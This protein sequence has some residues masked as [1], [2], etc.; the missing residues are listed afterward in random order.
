MFYISTFYKCFKFLDFIKFETL[1]RDF[2]IKNK[3]KGTFIITPE[4]INATI[5]S[6]EE[7]SLEDLKIFIMKK[8]GDIDFKYSLSNKSP[9]KKLKIKI[10]NELVPSGTK[11]RPY[12]F[13]SQYLNADEWNEFLKNDNNLV[14]DV[15]NSY[16][17]YAGS[18]KN[19]ISPETKNF[20]E[21]KNFIKHNRDNLQ[22]KKIGIFCT[23]GI[24]CEKALYSLKEEG[25]KDVYQLKGG[26]LN[27]FNEAT[28]KSTWQGECFVFDERV[29]V[30]TNLKPGE[31]KQCYACRRPLSKKDLD[32]K[33]YV[34]GI[35]CHNCL[36]EK[37]ESDRLR[38]AERQK[39]LD[40]RNQ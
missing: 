2:C 31:F 4:G 12:D 13:K 29:T 20:K 21:F 38:Y 3:I 39:Q 1:V 17:N 34:K 7:S 32:R 27:F 28:D 11:G 15:R 10:R 40:L 24:R 23:G 30:D 16:E 26:I 8:I 6:L 9:F 33:E 37:S 35:S 5:C 22:G 25:L 14:I 19:S 36:K 18:F